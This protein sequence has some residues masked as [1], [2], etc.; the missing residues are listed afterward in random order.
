VLSANLDRAGVLLV[1]LIEQEQH[2]FMAKPKPRY[3]EVVELKTFRPARATDKG[4]SADRYGAFSE[5]VAY[6][7]WE[8]S[9]FPLAW[10]DSRTERT[11]ANMAD[12]DHHVDCWVRLH[13]GDLP[14]LWSSGGQEYNRDL[15]VIERDGHPLR[16]RSENEQ[17]DVLGLRIRQA[18]GSLALGERRHAQQSHRDP[19]SLACVRVGCGHSEGFLGRPDNFADVTQMQV[20]VV[21]E[22]EVPAA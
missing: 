22:V 12:S 15:I 4:V 10:F 9:L 18:G 17:G 8:G 13:V 3:V 16:R 6:E 2:R 19:A 14:I 21:D 5:S 20:L 11:V 7:G 1:R